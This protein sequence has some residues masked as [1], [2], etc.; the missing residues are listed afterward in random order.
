MQSRTSESG[1]T[2]CHKKQRALFKKTVIVCG[3]CYSPVMDQIQPN[4]GYE[5]SKGNVRGVV[6]MKA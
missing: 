5:T 1:R 6:K 4:G 3:G 2:K